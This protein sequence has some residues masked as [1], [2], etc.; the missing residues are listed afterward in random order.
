MGTLACQYPKLINDFRNA[1]DN[2]GFVS[3]VVEKPN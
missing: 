2:L 3:G 1:T